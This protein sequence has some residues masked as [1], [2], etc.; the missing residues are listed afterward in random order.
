MKVQTQ[1]I[2]SIKSSSLDTFDI[3]TYIGI[4]DGTTTPTVADT[5]LTNETLRKLLASSVKDLSLGT[6]RFEI[7]VALTEANGTII[8]EVA[9]F[10]QATGGLMGAKDLLGTNVTKTADKEVIII[11]E[12]E[13]GVVN[14]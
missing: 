11:L 6:Y 4:G 3:Y 1:Q 7:R 14:I 2:T 5:T 12:V 13:V 8:S 9:I 10:N